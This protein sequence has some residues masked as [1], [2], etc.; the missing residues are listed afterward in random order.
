[1]RFSTVGLLAGLAASALGGD[2]L[3]VEPLQGQEYTEASSL[4][5]TPDYITQEQ[6]L[7][8]TTAQFAAYKAII[9]ADNDG[10]GDL[11]DIQFLENSTA[12]WSPAV[13]GNMILIGNFHQ[14]ITG[15]K[16]LID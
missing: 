8:M 15:I 12:V 13:T 10:D 1:M 6:W 4:G 3:F 14:P 7:A 2:L 5:F 9:L 16:I 11:S